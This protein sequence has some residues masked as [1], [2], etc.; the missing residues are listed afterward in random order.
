MDDRFK[1]SLW[2]KKQPTSLT[3]PLWKFRLTNVHKIY[4]LQSTIS[5]QLGG[6]TDISSAS[7]KKIWGDISNSKPI[8]S[9]TIPSI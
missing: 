7:G 9:K 6:G 8:Q 2:C 4:I 1:K 3:I 5:N